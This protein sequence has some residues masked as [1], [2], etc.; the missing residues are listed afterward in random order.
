MMCNYLQTCHYYKYYNIQVL[1]RLYNF[2]CVFVSNINHI[3]DTFNGNNHAFSR[4]CINQTINT[5]VLRSK[6]IDLLHNKSN[7]TDVCCL[8]KIKTVNCQVTSVWNL[9]IVAYIIHTYI[10]PNTHTH[11][12]FMH[13][14][15]KDHKTPSLK[16]ILACS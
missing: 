1:Y 16:Y 5:K 9:V 3:C 8:D 6:C 11:S 14:S 4:W 12:K 10:H 7:Y 15:L 13:Q 2:M